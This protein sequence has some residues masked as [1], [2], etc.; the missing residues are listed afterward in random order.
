M[1]DSFATE[2]NESSATINNLAELFTQHL[3]NESKSASQPFVDRCL[4]M[5]EVT[6]VKMGCIV[7]GCAQTAKTTLVETVAGG[8][9]IASRNELRIRIAQVRKEKLKYALS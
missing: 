7:M 6:Q 3:A 9:N 5:Y 8:L 4:Q 1:K 2:F